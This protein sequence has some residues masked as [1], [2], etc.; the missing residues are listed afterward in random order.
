MQ[1]LNFYT[2]ELKYPNS[3]FL[4]LSIRVPKLK[5]TATIEDSIYSEKLF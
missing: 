5:T 4:A 2:L 1:N 3:R